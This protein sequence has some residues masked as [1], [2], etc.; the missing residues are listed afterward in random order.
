MPDALDR[1]DDEGRRLS[2]PGRFAGL[3]VPAISV[4][5]YRAITG[6]ALDMPDWLRQF[7]AI[8]TDAVVIVFA[9]GMLGVWWRTRR[10]DP[11]ALA[12]AVLGPAGVA[13]AYLVGE[14]L[15][16]VVR[17]QR[18]CAALIQATI[19][20]C[21]PPGDWS[22]PGNHSV[23]AGAAGVAVVLVCRAA[24]FWVVPVAVLAALSRVVVGVHY[25][26]DVAAGLA[27]GGVVTLLVVL[28]LRRPVAR[29][30]GRRCSR[31]RRRGFGT[32]V[33]RGPEPSSSPA[34]GR[35]RAGFR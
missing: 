26:H 33:G 34:E 24:V 7:A 17:E 35:S 8:A 12:V 20:G 31:P 3:D 14:A 2:G 18:P 19:V 10:G 22:F 11:R 21:P 6:F 28:P 25:P 4:L 13:V 15:N 30:I 9:V 27:L 1:R 23:V 29:L 5:W 16:S 32:P